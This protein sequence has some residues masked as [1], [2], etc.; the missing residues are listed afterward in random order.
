MKRILIT[1]MILIVSIPTEGTWQFCRLRHQGDWYADYPVAERKL[2]AMLKD[3]IR[4][5][6]APRNRVITTTEQNLSQCAFVV[7]SNIDS[8]FWSPNEARAIG[9]WA[10]KGGFLWTDGIWSDEAWESWN[11][12]LKKALPRAQVRELDSHHPIFNHPFQVPLQQYKAPEGG[13]VKNFAVE[14]DKGRLMILMTFNEKGCNGCGA[15]G[16]SWQDFEDDWQSKEAAWMFSINVLLY[17]M[18]H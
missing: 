3:V 17:I 14:D 13:W 9:D 1:I 4:I 2:T 6:A 5:D 10:K 7:I 15:V 8:L 16:D 18:T 11:K 12:Q